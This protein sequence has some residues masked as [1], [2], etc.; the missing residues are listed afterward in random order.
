MKASQ[1]PTVWSEPSPMQERVVL[2]AIARLAR[3]GTGLEIGDASAVIVVTEPTGAV[4]RHHMA[5]AHFNAACRFGWIANVAA[6][7]QWC[8]T[9][10]GR[11]AL[12]RRKSMPARSAG[13]A[14]RGAGHAGRPDRPVVGRSGTQSV[15]AASSEP[16]TTLDPDESP[17]AWLRQRRDRD[18]N[19][20][21]TDQEFT[22]GERL[23]AEFWRASMTPR[24]TMNWDRIGLGGGA[25]SGG[26]P[27]DRLDTSE[28]AAAARTRVAR[29]LA[30][31]GPDLAG[32]HVDTCS[33]LK[34]LTEIEKERAMSPRAG[35]Y[36]LQLA[37]RS[38]ARHYGY[39]PRT[40][41]GRLAPET[42][43]E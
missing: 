11:V 30:E 9:E 42:F 38:L 24:V 43:G 31:V 37:L 19:P 1:S 2:D 28:R 14:S 7:G 22:A 32:I 17:L 35:K 8:L 26:G 18:G 41:S 23:R 36:V 15:V 29:A 3:Q 16:T 40:P 33:H 13:K 34:G 39:L 27:R 20:F 25:G 12:R 5:Q 10:R 4:S 6:H 21:L